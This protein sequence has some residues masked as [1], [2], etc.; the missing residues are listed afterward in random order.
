MENLQDAQTDALGALMRKI[1]GYA[2]YADREQSRDAD[3]LHREFLAKGV[4]ALKNSMKDVQAELLRGGGLAHMGRLGDLGNK[5]DRVAERLR[6]ASYGYA[7]LM[8][9]NQINEAELSR[10]YEFDL[11]LVNQLHYC[12]EALKALEA[13][14]S[15]PDTLVARMGDL[16]KTVREF[17]SKIDER[18]KLLKGAI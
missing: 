2:G 10:I 17:D 4:T 14:T 3:R 9:H 18:E 12:E 7:G 13:A 15:T 6:H 16:E 8:A 5:L 11:G 1:P